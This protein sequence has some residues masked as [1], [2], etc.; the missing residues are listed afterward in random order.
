MKIWNIAGQLIS[1]LNEIPGGVPFEIST[2]GWPSGVYFFSLFFDSNEPITK[3][4][5]ISH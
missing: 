4:V 3:K 1:S 2:S 5:I